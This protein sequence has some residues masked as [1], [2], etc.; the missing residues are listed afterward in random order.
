MY[1]EF[2]GSDSCAD[3]TDPLSFFRHVS[4]S[5]N[6]LVGVKFQGVHPVTYRAR[7]Q[8][9][10][11]VDWGTHPALIKEPAFRAQAELR[12]IWTPI[13]KQLLEPVVLGNFRIPGCCRE[14]RVGGESRVA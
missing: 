4:A 6:S 8:S 14:V 12:A 9:W 10:N 5:L 1:K 2:E 3:I 11:G 13:R 7:E